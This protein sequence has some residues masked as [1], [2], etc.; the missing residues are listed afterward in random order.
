M[1]LPR[2]RRP[3]SRSASVADFST[4]PAP[5]RGAFPLTVLQGSNQGP[6]SGLPEE[7]VFYSLPDPSNTPDS[8]NTQPSPAYAVLPHL[9]LTTE[10]H[11]SPPATASPTHNPSPHAS[12]LFR[13]E[14]A[15]SSGFDAI[16]EHD[17]LDDGLWR[18]PTQMSRAK[19]MSMSLDP[20]MYTES[21][22]PTHS[23]EGYDVSKPWNSVPHIDEETS[24]AG[25][26]SVPALASASHEQWTETVDR[27]A[28]PKRDF[29]DLSRVDSPTRSKFFREDGLRVGMKPRQ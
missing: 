1:P 18:S 29:G 27:Y 17:E 16:P 25:V 4:P 3:S 21:V 20:P 23:G 13:D 19:S 26:S 10:V 22:K 2:F 15:V 12:G 24:G 8:Q 9:T 11:T 5:F 7:H 28:G 6:A 14:K